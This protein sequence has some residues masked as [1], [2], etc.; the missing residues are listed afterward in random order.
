MTVPITPVPVRLPATVAIPAD[1]ESVNSAGVAAYVQTLANAIEYNQPVNDI[2]VADLTSPSAHNAVYNGTF[3]SG[4][5]IANDYYGGRLLR[6]YSLTADV[7]LVAKNYDVIATYGNLAAARTLTLDNTGITDGYEML[8]SNLPDDHTAT[9]TNELNVTARFVH[10]SGVGTVTLKR[11][12]G[13]ISAGGFSERL[14]LMWVG[15]STT[16][17]FRII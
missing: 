11:V 6:Y 3:S 10:L 7:T 4:S 14:R 13:A 8:V 1:G 17:G 15:P 9:F 5:L 2:W 12:A 16:G